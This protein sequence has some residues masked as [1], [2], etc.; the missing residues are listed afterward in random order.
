MPC[1]SSI[2]GIVVSNGGN[3][4]SIGGNAGIVESIDGSDVSMAVRDVS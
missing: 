3:D 1:R 2:A 4:V